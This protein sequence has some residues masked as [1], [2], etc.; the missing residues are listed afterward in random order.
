MLTASSWENLLYFYSGQTMFSSAYTGLRIYEGWTRR[1]PVA[2]HY[3]HTV[4]AVFFSLRT[5]EPGAGL[6]VF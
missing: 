6:N 2:F 4:S 5:F 1:I 3:C